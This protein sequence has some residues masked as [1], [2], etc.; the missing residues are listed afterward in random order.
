[1]AV[2]ISLAPP[3]EPCQ[4]FQLNVI[5]SKAIDGESGASPE[6][7]AWCVLLRGVTATQGLATLWLVF[8]A[9]SKDV[10]TKLPL[11]LYLL[12]STWMLTTSESVWDA[13]KLKQAGEENTE[14]RSVS[15]SRYEN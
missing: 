12:F 1:M 14:N 6:K 3:T 8:P 9:A 11:K 7:L 4:F 2:I 13:V 10:S 15:V 5:S